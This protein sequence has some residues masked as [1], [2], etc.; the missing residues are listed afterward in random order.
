MQGLNTFF[1]TPHPSFPAITP[2]ASYM[3]HC[4]STST[5]TS[6]LTR[7]PRQ[8]IA[9][10]CPRCAWCA[11]CDLCCDFFKSNP[12]EVD[13]WQITARLADLFAARGIKAIRRASESIGGCDWI[14]PKRKAFLEAVSDASDAAAPGYAAAGL[15]TTTHFV[16][17]WLF[18]FLFA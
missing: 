7:C 16:G 9:V 8:V 10:A 11:W 12:S 4:R 2:P 6:T 14:A 5:P 17:P 15:V 13:S 1:L 18:P 3:D